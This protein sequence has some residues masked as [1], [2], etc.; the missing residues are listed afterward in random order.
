MA[1]TV[2]V[3]NPSP[4]GLL[5]VNPGGKRKRSKGGAKTMATKRRK[6]G[7]SARRKSNP[8]FGRSRRR[9]TT[10][11]RNPSL[12]S[13]SVSGS[14]VTGGIAGFL[15]GSLTNTVAGMFGTIGGSS[16]WADIART[17][18][19]A[20]VV[21]FAAEKIPYTRKYASWAYIGGWAVVGAKIVAIGKQYLGGVVPGLTGMRD[22]VSLPVTGYSSY[23]GPTTAPVGIQDIVQVPAQRY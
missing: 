23:Y 7:A 21:G 17:A 22:I 9:K 8:L 2:R 6:S 1:V 13:V 18:A 10:R 15:G 19:A 11:R 5:I 14:P 16:P 12:T 3:K 20:F 4:A